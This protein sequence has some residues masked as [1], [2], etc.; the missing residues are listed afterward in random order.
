MWSYKGHIIQKFKGHK[1]KS[2]WSMCVDKGEKSVFTGGGDNSVR[3]WSLEKGETTK[4][5]NTKSLNLQVP[6]KNFN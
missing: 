1:G 6:L 2:I 5:E 3:M 4:E